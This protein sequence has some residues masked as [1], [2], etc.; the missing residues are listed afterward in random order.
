MSPSD[1]ATLMHRIAR[2]DERAFD[3]FYERHKSTV[4]GLALNMLGEPATA[5]EA[6]L[7]VFVQIWRHAS[8]YNARH[9]SPR[10]WLLAIARN[11]AI[12][13][14]RRG[15]VRPDL[16]QPQWADDPLTPLPAPGDLE[17]DVA[18]RD[19][20]RRVVRAVRELP[21]AQRQV[22]RL[23]Y[24]QGYSHG[25]IAEALALPLGTVKTRIRAAMQQLKAALGAT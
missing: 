14:L 18:D 5:E 21:E 1:D 17:T 24:F 19:E 25:Q 20:R 2:G 15:K 4:Y 22:L 9:A 8:E 23:A 3:R 16:Q 7:D 12:D 11:K 13:R 6:T 10:T